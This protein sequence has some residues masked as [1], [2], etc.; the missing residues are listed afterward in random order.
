MTL[1]QKQRLFT[2]LIA[3]LI[4]WAYAQGF[5]LSVGDAYRDSRVFG[6]MGTFEGYGSSRSNHKVRLA[7]DLNLFKPINGDLVYQRETE[8]YKE[9]GEYWQSLH[10]LCAWGGEDNRNDGNH[11][12][13]YYNGRW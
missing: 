6:E 10:E 4:S 9:M 12:S 5:E 1:G 3:K 13:F 8:N 11:F 2:K 7:M